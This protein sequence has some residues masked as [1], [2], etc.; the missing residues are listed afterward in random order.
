MRDLNRSIEA[1][2]RQSTDG[3]V[4]T[5]E[6]LDRYKQIIQR[7]QPSLIIET[8][9]FS[10]RS[11]RWFAQIGRCKVVT[12][13]V[14]DQ[15]A[16]EVRHSGIAPEWVTFL[17]GNSVDPATVDQVRSYTADATGPVMVVLD[18]DHSGLHVW[19][20]MRLYGPLVTPGSYM[21]VEDGIVRWL[22]AQQK[23]LGPYEG[24][25]LDAIELFMR[26]HHDQ[27]SIDVVIEDLH[28]VT[29][30]PAGWLQRRV[31]AEAAA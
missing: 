13:D 10:G 4:K 8:G 26:D 17:H 29:L 12:I 27:W 30:F 2:A 23:P 5:W 9:T 1:C 14:H 25:P 3:C 28:P 6:D 15:V 11:A 21:V 16:P 24:S 19:A 22:P 18:S 7:V 31:R 20:E